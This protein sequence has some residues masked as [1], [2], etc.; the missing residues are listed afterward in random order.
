MP[1]LFDSPV[2][3]EGV[4]PAHILADINKVADFMYAGNAV[5]TVRSQE[6]G[7]RFT[8]KVAKAKPNPNYAPRDAWF[9][10]VLTGPDNTSSYSYMGMITA[11]D[12]LLKTKSF[13]FTGASRISKS[14][15]SAKAFLY[16]LDH[17]ENRKQYPP[18]V[19][20]WHAGHCG[21]CNRLL[22]VGDS[23]ERGFGSVCLS[24]M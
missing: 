3:V 23:I 18:K 17:L 1:T 13:R 24:K 15:T 22:T 4:A 19:D 12:D 16:C 6:T 11:A 5:F 21:R 10:K 2:V 9:V 14:A 20:I 8:F 7:T